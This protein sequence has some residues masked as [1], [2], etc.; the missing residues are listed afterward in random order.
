MRLGKKADGIMEE[1]VAGI[2]RFRKNMLE[3]LCQNRRRYAI[4]LTRRIRHI[5]ILMTVTSR[6]KDNNGAAAK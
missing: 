3:K 4:L 1:V 6:C 2:N 5:M